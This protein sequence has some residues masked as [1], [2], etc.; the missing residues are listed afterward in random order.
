[1]S[2]T[3]FQDYNKEP[4]LREKH[5]SSAGV[6]EMA[7]QRYL[8]GFLLKFPHNENHSFTKTAEVA[9]RGDNTFDTTSCPNV[10]RL[11]T[12]LA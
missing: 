3:A 11:D 4:Y 2:L 8:S 6:G 1:M 9:T 7:A 12:P 5:E 10:E